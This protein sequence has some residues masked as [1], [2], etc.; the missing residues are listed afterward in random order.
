VPA[1]EL[2]NATNY[3]LHIEFANAFCELVVAQREFLLYLTSSVWTLAYSIQPTGL[4]S[5][6]PS[7]PSL[8]HNTYQTAPLLLC[9]TRVRYRPE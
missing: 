3:P 2:D 9:Y 5:S 6:F 4:H 1:A 8:I 7:S